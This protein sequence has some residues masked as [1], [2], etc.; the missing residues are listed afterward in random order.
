M[1]L[2]VTMLMFVS[3]PLLAWSGVVVAASK[4]FS[5]VNTSHWSNKEINFLVNKEVINGYP[6]G[7][8]GVNDSITRAQAATMIMR[9]FAWGTS[10]E[11]ND[12]GYSDVRPGKHWAYNEITGVYNMDIF[13]PTGKFQPELEVTRGELR[14]VC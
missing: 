6:D 7:R 3:V 14:S 8:C 2:K 12:P 11:W 13:M 10:G 9:S 5:D 4:S 1:K